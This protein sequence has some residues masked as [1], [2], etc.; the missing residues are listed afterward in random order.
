MREKPR[1]RRNTK[2]EEGNKLRW[3]EKGKQRKKRRGERNKE[4]GERELKEPQGEK[5]RNGE[6]EN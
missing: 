2:K 4:T 6:R 5:Q 3:E 1:G